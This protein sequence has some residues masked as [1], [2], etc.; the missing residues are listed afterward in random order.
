M[1]ESVVEMEDVAEVGGCYERV[2]EVDV[3]REAHE[4]FERLGKE[5]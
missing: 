3:G 5:A 1:G 4:R 2:E